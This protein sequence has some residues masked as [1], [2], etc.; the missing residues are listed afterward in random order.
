MLF[1]AEYAEAA[2]N[3]KVKPKKLGDLCVLR[4]K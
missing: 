4:G 3:A 2:E 1:T